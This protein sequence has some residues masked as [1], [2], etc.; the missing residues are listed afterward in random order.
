MVNQMPKSS[1]QKIYNE[2]RFANGPSQFILHGVWT[3]ISSGLFPLSGY[4]PIL[5]LIWLVSGLI[6]ITTTFTLNRKII[7]MSILISTALAVTTG[8]MFFSYA[9]LGG[10]MRSDMQ[11]A[12]IALF[13]LIIWGLYLGNLCSRQIWDKEQVK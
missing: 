9:L 2:F 1:I 3:I 7:R 13:V 10:D 5:T 11:S 4:L 12:T 8:S 6:T